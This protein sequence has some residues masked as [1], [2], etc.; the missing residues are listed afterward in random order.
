MIYPFFYLFLSLLTGI[1][2]NNYFNINIHPAFILIFLFLSYIFKDLIGFI[3]LNI[4]TILIG[5]YISYKE[6]PNFIQNPVY[7][8]C[9][10][11]SLPSIATEKKSFSCKIL[12]SDNTE[13]INKEI[14]IKTEAQNI[15]FLSRLQLFG[16]AYIKDKDIIVSPIEGFLKVDNSNNPLYTIFNLKEKMI[17]NYQ[18]Y[19]IN[20][21]LLGIGLALI[22]GEKGKLQEETKSKFSYTGL[23]HLLAI[24]GFHVAILAFILNF[25]LFFLNERVR[26]IILMIL[27]PFYAIFTGLQAPVV[28]AVFMINLFLLSKI[29]YIKSNNLN[30]L[31][32]VGFIILLISPDSLFSISFQLSFLATLGIILF[33]NNYKIDLKNPV[34]TF[35]ISSILISI[36]AVLFTMPVVLYYFGGFSIISIIATPIASL[37]LYPYLAIGFLNIMTIFQNQFLAKS[38]DYIGIIFYKIVDFFNGIGGYFV[39]FNPS[40]FAISVY[41]LIL[42]GIFIFNIKTILRITIILITTA[43]FLDISKEKSEYNKIYVFETKKYPFLFIKTKTGNCYYLGRYL[44]FDVKNLINKENCK[45]KIYIIDKNELNFVDDRIFNIFEEVIEYKDGLKFEDFVLSKQ[46]DNIQI[47]YKDKPYK[48]ENIN[49]FL[50]LD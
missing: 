26:Y 1:L 9:V 45:E 28:R 47:I 2:L 20:P 41:L 43:I 4:A 34:L 48:I 30:I 38:M 17:Q 16:K 36:V 32:F 10:V 44:I 6:I 19:S 27:L 49:N 31:F 33:I 46:E 50:K 23:S 13:L 15:Y 5:F 29:L 21:Q 12:D 40:I 14:K 3:I 24:S 42:T 39:G 37:P 8:E 11:N 7:I 22:F 35:F 18:K 25:F